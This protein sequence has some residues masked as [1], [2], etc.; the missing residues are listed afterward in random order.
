M[1]TTELAEICIRHSRDPHLISDTRGRVLFANPAFHQTLQIPSDARL[2]LANLGP[3]NLE[4]HLQEAAIAAGEHDADANSTPHALHFSLMAELDDETLPLEVISQPLRLNDDQRALRLITLQPQRRRTTAVETVSEDEQDGLDDSHFHS[5]DANCRPTLQFARRVAASDVRVML[6]G[7]SGTGKTRLARAI[8]QSSRRTRAPFVEINCAAIPE[9]LLESELF[10]HA[11]GAFSGAVTDRVGR[12]EAA[13]GG[14][15]FLD[16]I[17]E[18]SPRLQ[19]KL[20]RAVQ[21]GAFE[22]VGENTTRQVDVRILSASNQNL[23]SRVEAG[24]FRTDLFYRLAV[25]TVEIPPLRERPRD[26]EATLQAYEVHHGIRIAPHLKERLQ[27]HPWPGNF[28][29]LE[30]VFEC[31]TLHARNGQVDDF[32]LPQPIRVDADAADTIH[33]PRTNRHDPAHVPD[34]QPNDR[35]G[36]PTRDGQP[37]EHPEARRLR[38][39][40]VAHAGNRSQTARA[41]GMDR[42][43]LW[44]KLHRYQLV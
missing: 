42:S 5:H 27:E 33:A 24:A 2:T 39:A 12:F 30:N 3:L 35:A 31:L 17:G 19:A 10:G 21:D 7:E 40:L 11:R 23:R 15:L 41:L 13:D 44:R 1:T 22:R 29:E 16:E 38:E 25:A 8:H 32:P 28:R 43:T 20:L 26:L 18:M 37:S 14:T 9:E 34:G 4:Q 6:M 36:H